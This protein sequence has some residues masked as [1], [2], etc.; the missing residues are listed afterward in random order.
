MKLSRQ[1]VTKVANLAKLLLTPSKLALFQKQLSE[2]I[3]FNAKKLSQV[4]RE[5]RTEGHQPQE[6][7]QADQ[8]RPSL[9]QAEALANAKESERGFFT[10]PKVLDD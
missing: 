1:D 8:P 3:D 5:V 2:V 7:G 9:S 10:T 6:F 4:K